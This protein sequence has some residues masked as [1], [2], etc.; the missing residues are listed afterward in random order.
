MK[1]LSIFSPNK[2]HNCSSNLLV[3]INLANKIYSLIILA[4]RR[5]FTGT[6]AALVPLCKMETKYIPHHKITDFLE[7]LPARRQSYLRSRLKKVRYKAGAEIIQQGQSGHYLGII[8][9]GRV[10][11]ENGKSQMQILSKGQ[12]FGSEMLRYGKPSTY[13]ITAQT[14][15]VVKV[16]GRA[17]WLAPSPKIRRLKIPS[18]IPKPGKTGWIMLI[19]G[20]ALAMVW[21]VLG[22]SIFEYANNTIPDRFIE[23]GRL[24]LAEKYLVYAISLDSDSAKLYGNLG[25]TLALQEKDQEAIEAYEH[26]IDLDEYLPWIHNNLGVVLLEK[27]QNELAEEHFQYALE[28]NPLNIDI[29]RNLGNTYYAQENWDSAADIYQDALDL[30]FT[31]VDTKAAWAGLILQERRLVEARLVWEDVL[32]QN[33]RHSLALQG[34]GV[35]SLLEGEPALA[36][37]YF[38]AASYITPNDP[39]LHF[40]IGMALE[41]LD[42]PDEAASEYQYVTKSGADPRLVI[43]ANTLLQIVRE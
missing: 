3:R 4:S 41:D 14:D 12:Y 16:L 29:Y 30:D 39:T 38:D 6:G 37:I 35:V 17:D 25:D 13:T 26:A 33:P 10:R 21:L 22:P 34:L 28:L 43:L 20:L 31:L 5:Y 9:R 42:K 11:Q 7:E 1:G 23:E 36:M 40:Y 19:S 18:W 15:T 27:G 32:R 24:D 8:E 2:S